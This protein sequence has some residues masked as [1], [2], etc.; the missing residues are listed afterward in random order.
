MDFCCLMRTSPPL[1]GSPTHHSYVQAHGSNGIG[2]PPLRAQML[3][4]VVSWDFCWTAGRSRA[5]S[6]EAAG[7]TGAAGPKTRTVQLCLGN[8]GSQLQRERTE[9]EFREIPAGV[10]AWPHM[11]LRPSCICD[12]PNI[13]L[14]KLV[15]T[16]R[17]VK[18]LLCL[19]LLELVSDT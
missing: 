5:L 1:L 6:M 9:P 18:F 3:C 10:K 7:P 2:R 11:F 15:C 12:F 14:S 8:E 4:G 16:P 19:N 17:A 13:W